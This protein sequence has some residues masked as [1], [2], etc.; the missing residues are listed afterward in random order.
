MTAAARTPAAEAR[1]PASAEELAE[2]IRQAADSGEPLSPV[3]GQTA[4]GRGI[5]LTAGVSPVSLRKLK[6]VIDYPHDDMTITVEAGITLAE[7]QRTL[8]RHGQRLPVEV[9]Q[10]DAATLGGAIATN[11]SGPRRYGCGTFR[12][13]V[14]G[15]TA[16]D[17]RG[18]TFSGGGRVVKNV[19]GYDFCKLL[20][21]SRGGLAVI[22][23][24]TL[25]VLPAPEA[26]TILTAPV[27]SHAQFAGALNAIAES[28]LAPTAIDYVQG[29]AWEP[30]LMKSRPAAFGCLILGHE[31]TRDEI[32]WLTSETQNLGRENNLRFTKAAPE[33][34]AALWSEL[35]D[36]PAA[37]GDELTLKANVVPS[38]VPGFLESLHAIDPQASV[39]ARAGNGIVFARMSLAAGEVVSAQA[40]SLLPAARKLS[41]NCVVYAAPTGTDLTSQASFGAP[42]E[43]HEVYRQVKQT[44]DPYGILSPGALVSG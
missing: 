38:G 36:F 8:A 17:G 4:I 25:K 41:G 6:R 12:D 32:A 18:V 35:A 42:P 7:L 40:K 14:I 39:C 27:A 15:I 9:P 33:E 19:A 3:G 24:V 22:T 29:A 26:S 21:G 20:I 31:G 11:E 16:I 43:A 10:A 2:I 30:M 28:R 23:Q 1:E 5:P 13:Y 37:G 44:F 34:Q